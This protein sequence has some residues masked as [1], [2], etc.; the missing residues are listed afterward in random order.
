[1]QVVKNE[2]TECSL[3]IENIDFGVV[4]EMR[5]EEEDVYS[6][7]TLILLE[8]DSNNKT[9]VCWSPKKEKII[10]LNK[11]E[12]VFAFYPEAR[13]VLGTPCFE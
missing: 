11:E 6:T 3:T 13:I 9:F 2:A 10:Y 5:E 4:F 8:K 1:M 12:K 7:D